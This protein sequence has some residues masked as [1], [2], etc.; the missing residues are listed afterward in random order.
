MWRGVLLISGIL[1]TA[2]GVIGMFLPL[3]PTVPLLLLAAACFARSSERF[4]SWLLNQKHLGPIV[5]TYLDGGGMPLRAKVVT[6]GVLWISLGGS[7]LLC[8]NKSWWLHLLLGTIGL[9]VTAYLVKLPGEADA[10]KVS[11][12]ET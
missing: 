2:L 7:S 12:A 3:I 6:I 9:G 8:M 4:H 11:S 1:S 10:G 5:R